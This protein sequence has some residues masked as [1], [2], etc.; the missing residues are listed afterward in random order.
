MVYRKWEADLLR[1]YGHG[2]PDDYLAFDCETTGGS[3]EWDLPVEFGFTLVRDRVVIKKHAWVLDWTRY[4][5]I[6]LDWLQDQI[7]SL[8]YVYKLRGDEYIYT[9]PYLQKHGRDPYWVMDKA[10]RLFE[11]NRVGGGVFVGHNALSFDYPLLKNVFN[12]LLQRDWVFGPSE[13]FDTGACEKMILCAGLPDRSKHLI[14]A[15]N[16]SLADFFLRVVRSHRV[17][18]KWNLAACVDRYGF[19]DR[20]GINKAELH[21]A[22]MDSYVCHLLMEHHR[23]EDVEAARPAT[24]V[25]RPRKLKKRVGQG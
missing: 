7:E 3:R 13:L 16:E 22:K 9:I 15:R 12:E 5:E 10:Y 14:P 19:V 8:Q 25:S 2:L 24:T 11:A 21:G 20:F 18:V 4:P 1:W 6:E 17:G 23:V